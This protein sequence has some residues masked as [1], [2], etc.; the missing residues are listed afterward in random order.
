[1][2][3]VANEF[4]M[5]IRENWSAHASHLI[6]LDNGEVFCVFFYGT[7][8]ANDDVRIYGSLRSSEGVWSEPVAL[9]EDDGVP[10]WNPVLFRRNDG[11]VILFYKVGKTIAN[12]Q[13]RIMLSHDNCRTW[14]NSYEMIPGDTSGGR[15]PVRNKPIYLSDGTILAP[16]ST[17]QG[18]WKCFFD[19]STD[20]GKTWV[21]TDDIRLPAEMLEKYDTLISRGII[22]PTVWETEAGIH[23]LMRSSEGFVFRTDSTDGINWTQPQAIELPNNNSG[24]DA[25]PLPNGRIIL[26]CNPVSDNWGKRTPLSLFLSRD[27]GFHFELLTHLVTCSR[28]GYAYPA[29]Q[30]DCGKLHI[31]YTWDRETICYMC[32]EDI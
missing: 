31:S 24:I 32:F 11:S 3:I 7:A 13:T 9:S 17:E 18:E 6:P 15:G 14:S 21:R 22:Q 8:E 26:A 28:G 1:M 29:L 27:N 10:H 23:A 12:W 5:P 30:Y 2:K 25:V 4:V 20:D 19:R 16:G